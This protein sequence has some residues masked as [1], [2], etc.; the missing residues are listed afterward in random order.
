MIMS[1]TLKS[2]DKKLLR[3]ADPFTGLRR[4][5]HDIDREI[6]ALLVCPFLSDEDKAIVQEIFS[7]IV[8]C[9]SLL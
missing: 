7:N 5:L 6:D 1:S 3:R 4:C 2:L 8:F 9:R